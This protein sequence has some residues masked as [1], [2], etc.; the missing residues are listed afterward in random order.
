MPQN[1][2]MLFYL[3]YLYKI[4]Q[5]IKAGSAVK[6]KSTKWTV[7]WVLNQ[8]KKRLNWIGINDPTIT[9]FVNKWEKFLSKN[10]R[11]DQ[12][13]NELHAKRLS[14]ELTAL[15]EHFVNEVLWDIP[16]YAEVT[17][18]LINPDLL[19]KGLRELLGSD[20]YDN[21][22]IEVKL[23]LEDA[24]KVIR[25]GVWTPAVMM[26]LRAVEA[27]LR[28]YYEKI[29]GKPPIDE[30]GKFLTWYQM[31]NDLRSTGKVKTTLIGYLDFLRD[32]R[33]EADHPGKR[34]EQEIAERTLI[35]AVEALKIMKT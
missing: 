35:H 6:P 15:W 3:G 12:L 4:L 23:D 1:Y 18:G 31:L 25:I 24:I 21:L 27:S 20:V 14:D 22:P 34:F 2:S 19:R 5:D 7:L 26:T 10:Y 29:M 13:L 17:S 9:K 33:N 16:L 32:R 11:G 30:K 8:F 28:K